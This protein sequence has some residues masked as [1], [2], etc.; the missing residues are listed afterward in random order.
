MAECENKQDYIVLPGTGGS[1]T[2]GP[3]GPQGPAGPAGP[4]N[5]PL[6]ATDVSVT[7]LPYT[8]VQEVLDVLL[9]VNLVVS[10]FNTNPNTFEIGQ[11]ITSAK[12]TW[13]YNKQDIDSQEIQSSLG[14]EALAIA[15]REKIISF[16]P[17][18]GATTQFTLNTDDGTNIVNTNRSI[19]F[20]NGIY[21]GDAVPPP[22]LD[23]NFIRGL[24]KKLQ[25]SRQT[26]FDSNAANGEYAWFAHPKSFGVANF[27]AGGFTGGFQA[28]V[29]ISYTNA[30]G[31]T[32]DYYVYQSDFPDIGPV[33]IITT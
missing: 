19:Q 5:L 29:T 16:A 8:T 25:N 9:Y 24:A 33:K 21:Y 7:N 17:A 31:Y 11:T 10:N 12:F 22:A 32:E 26:T 14:T 1:G 27:S 4:V 13:T 28:P 2:P 23:S 6:P 30:F 18:L 20:F 3:A 15:D